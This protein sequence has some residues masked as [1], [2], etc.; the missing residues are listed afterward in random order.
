[1]FETYAA[2][3]LFPVW[4]ESHDGWTRTTTLFGACCTH[5]S[6]N[7]C[8]TTGSV[9]LYLSV[10]HFSGEYQL[11]SAS[12]TSPRVLM[13]D[14][15]ELTVKWFFYAWCRASE[16]LP[17]SISR[18]AEPVLVRFV[19]KCLEM[20]ADIPRGSTTPRNFRTVRHFSWKASLNSSL[21]CSGHVA[22]F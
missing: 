7:R 21:C 13:D 3:L 16:D 5:R 14:Y 18:A 6:T 8:P 17:L 12:C 19:K 2:I 20:F 1:M 22:P 4:F 10:G 11:T 9:V 15:D